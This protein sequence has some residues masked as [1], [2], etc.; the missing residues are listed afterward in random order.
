VWHSVVTGFFALTGLAA[1]GFLGFVFTRFQRRQVDGVILG[2]AVLFMSGLAGACWLAVRAGLAGQ[3]FAFTAAQTQ[4]FNPA[5]VVL[6]ALPVANL[7]TSLAKRGREPSTPV[8]FGLAL[9]LVGLGFFFL[10][11]GVPFANESLQVPILF[12]LGLYLLHTTGELFLSPVGLS[13]VTKLSAP[14]VVGL[15]MG[16]WFLASSLAHIVAAQIAQATGS[17]TIAGAVVD[18]AA[19]MAKY[20]STFT[21]I[22]WWGVGAGVLVLALSPFLKRSMHG[23]N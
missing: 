15:M 2:Y 14:Q 10:V 18:P 20:V 4:S 13:M 12:L 17:E 19:Q 11:A 22:G 23:V 1:L 9:I 6:L 3:P 8:K 5:F 16:V 7:W 21:E